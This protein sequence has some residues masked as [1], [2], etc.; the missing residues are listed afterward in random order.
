MLQDRLLSEVDQQLPL[1]GHVTGAF[2]QFDFVER[3]FAAGFLMRAQEVI[4]SDPEG[5]A[6]A[7]AIFRTVTAGDAV[8]FFKS[9]VQ[10][11]DKLFERTEF[12][13]YLIAIG[14]AD[15]LG[16]ENVPV[17][18]QLELLCGQRIGAVAIGNELQGFAREFLKFGKSHAHSQDAGSDI[19]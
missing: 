10:P 4:V 1:A 3:L 7:G 13:G 12:F 2:Q 11:F 6:V 19:S 9:A 5:Y 17:F 18:L 14:Q 16:D 15:D 8:G